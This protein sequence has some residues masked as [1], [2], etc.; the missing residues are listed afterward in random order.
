[1]DCMC[2]RS[3]KGKLRVYRDKYRKGAKLTVDAME[4]VKAQLGTGEDMP[5][6]DKEKIREQ[7]IN[8]AVDGALRMYAKHIGASDADV[9]EV[10]KE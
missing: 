4:A 3:K 7:K 1:M 6:G 5:A 10:L 9:E 8:N 2:F